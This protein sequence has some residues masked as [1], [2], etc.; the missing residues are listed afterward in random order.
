MPSIVGGAARAAVEGFLDT[1]NAEK[2]RNAYADFVA[3][4]LTYIVVLVI[5][6]FVGK[7]L[8]NSVIV[9]LFTCVRPA[10]STWH[11]LGL[12][13]FISLLLP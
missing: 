13:V 9:D 12:L 10:R 7:L 2:R 8:W 1:G 5:L 6:S 3:V 11:I 4:V